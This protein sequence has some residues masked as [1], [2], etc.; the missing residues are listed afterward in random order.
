L[1]LLT[2]DHIRNDAKRTPEALVEAIASGE[3]DFALANVISADER[4]YLDSREI[5]LPPQ[6]FIFCVT[7]GVYELFNNP[8]DFESAIISLIKNAPTAEA[9]TET[10]RHNCEQH[11]RDDY[12]AAFAFVT[13]YSELRAALKNPEMPPAWLSCPQADWT[14]KFIQPAGDFFL[15]KKERDARPPSPLPPTSSPSPNPAAAKAISNIRRSMHV[16]WLAVLALCATAAYGAHLYLAQLNSSRAVKADSR[17][18]T[19]NL[20]ASLGEQ[21]GR[22]EKLGKTVE[23]LD[24]RLQQSEKTSTSQDAKLNALATQMDSVSKSLEATG[25]AIKQLEFLITELKSKN[26]SSPNPPKETPSA[27]AAPPNAPIDIKAVQLRLIE[28]GCMQGKADGVSG[29]GT[30]NAIRRFEEVNGLKVTGLPS[31]Q[32]LDAFSG[33]PK[34][35]S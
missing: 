26:T 15:Q 23:L 1:Q 18:Q 14:K 32:L 27:P 33:K 9:F 34:R 17:I 7:D 31:Q 3:H 28:L 20:L 12:S 24:A 4:F 19:S 13:P 25:A 16:L 2:F 5:P 22:L 10:L 30:K 6:S 35:C 21:R 29:A 11:K 8:R